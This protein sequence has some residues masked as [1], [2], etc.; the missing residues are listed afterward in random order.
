MLSG[1]R[2]WGSTFRV[3]FVPQLEY[4]QGPRSFPLIQRVILGHLLAAAKPDIR[5]DNYFLLTETI[6]NNKGKV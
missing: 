6:S 3:M 4:L 2:G 1:F 5:G